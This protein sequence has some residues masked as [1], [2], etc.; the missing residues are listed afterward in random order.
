MDVLI[1]CPTADGRRTAA[2]VLWAYSTELLRTPG[3]RRILVDPDPEDEQA[4]QA[5]MDIGFQ[6]LGLYTGE[7]R[8]AL[9]LAVGRHQLRSLAPGDWTGRHRS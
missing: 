1:T 7:D 5:A 6:S 3:V 4:I 9:L 2:R 8:T